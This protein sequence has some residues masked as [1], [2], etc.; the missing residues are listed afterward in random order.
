MKLFDNIVEQEADI[1]ATMSWLDNVLLAKGYTPAEVGKFRERS[2]EHIAQ[3]KQSYSVPKGVLNSANTVFFLQRQIGLF[4]RYKRPFSVML[5]TVTAMKRAGAWQPL[6]PAVAS[7]AL[8]QLFT[9]LVASLRQIDLVGSIGQTGRT[10]PLIILAETKEDGAAI[11]LRRLRNSL[12]ALSVSVDGGPAQL[13]VVLS[14]AEFG[15]ETNQDMASFIDLV[16]KRHKD[17]EARDQ[18][19]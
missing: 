7:Q 19:V 1:G 15:K 17:A 2:T 12:G 18:P 5:A 13:H 8:P 14:Y 9:A 11:L 10:V 3:R 16:K 6:T 4:V